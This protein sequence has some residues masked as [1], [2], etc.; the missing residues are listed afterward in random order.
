MVG[1]SNQSVILIQIDA[2]S[3]AEF[4]ISEFEVSRVDCILI[5]RSFLQLLSAV[6]GTCTI[7]AFFLTNVLVHVPVKEKRY[8]NR[9]ND[10]KIIFFYPC[11]LRIFVYLLF[12]LYKSVK[13][14][15]AITFLF[16]AISS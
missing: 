2:S 3:F 1:E 15:L 16:S 6:S 4:E 9:R 7:V 8:Q 14:F 5:N 12:I 11:C 10:T 13:R